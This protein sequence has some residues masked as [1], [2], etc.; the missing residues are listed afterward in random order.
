M[1]SSL[2]PSTPEHGAS[3][4]RLLTPAT[5]IFTAAVILFTGAGVSAVF[6]KMPTSAGR[7]EL[8][9]AGNVDKKLVSV[10]LPDQ[11]VAVLTKDEMD[12]MVLPTFDI[13]P[14][15]D[16]GGEKYTQIYEA[17]ASLVSLNTET[18]VEEPVW[19]A[20]PQKFEPMRQAVEEKPISIEP[21][22]R[23]FLSKPVSVSTTE[24]SDELLQRF[25]FAENS[26]A[27]FERSVPGQPTDPFAG[28]T[29]PTAS[30]QPLQPLQLANLSPLLPLQEDELMS[31]PALTTK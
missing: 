31:L 10:P 22:N 17:P 19:T 24:K 18:T 12:Q 23:D 26:R 3:T 9:H 16:S 29:Q 28:T 6:W 27:E 14:I 5:R 30:L 21:I 4:H 11:S 7:Y 20:S 1:T 13:V 25:Y 8:C 2:P 15:T